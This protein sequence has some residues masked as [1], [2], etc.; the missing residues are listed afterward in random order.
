MVGNP[1]AGKS[2]LTAAL[3]KKAS[4]FFLRAFSAARPVSEVDEKTAG[5]IPHEF[6]SKKYGRITIYDFAGYREFYNSHAA[7]LQNAVQY[8]PPIFLLVVD[9]TD[10][11][12]VL[13]ENILHWLSILENQ[14]TSADS[15]PHVVIVGSHIDV[16][17]A[18]DKD[19]RDK[20]SIV[21]SLR[22]YHFKNLEYAGFVD[23]KC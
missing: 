1:S 20:A 16:L 14:C 11:N 15:K 12:K 18:R 13:K 10:E 21:E 17:E 23:I 22:S 8:S 5:V 6:E 7:L 19:P 4:S 2:T 3:Q 9:L